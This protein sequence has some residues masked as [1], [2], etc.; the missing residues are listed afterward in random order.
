MG[1]GGCRYDAGN[2]NDYT[3]SFCDR[4]SLNGHRQNE[5]DGGGDEEEYGG[6]DEEE[7]GDTCLSGYALVVSYQPRSETAPRPLP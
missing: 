7:Y 1:R 6:D 4:V 5:E 3:R 2:I